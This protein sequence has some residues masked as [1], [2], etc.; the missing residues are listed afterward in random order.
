M[1]S[2]VKI[3]GRQERGTFVAFPKA[4]LESNEYATLTLPERALLLDVFAQYNG[5]NNGS[6]SAAWTLVSKR[7]WRSRDTL[8]RALHGLLEK[9]FLQKTRQGGLHRRCSFYA[10]SWLAIN[11][12]GR[13]LDT[14]PTAVASNAW[15]QGGQ[16]T[17]TIALQ[18][19]VKRAV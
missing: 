15:R 6:L 19:G 7:G 14:R 9:G 13:G 16:K 3:K 18:R 4:I 12:C 17:W 11:E 8:G 2:R 1:Q 5:R 10:V